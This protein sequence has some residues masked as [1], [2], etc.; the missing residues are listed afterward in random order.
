MVSECF[1]LVYSEQGFTRLSCHLM[2]ALITFYDS[3][4]TLYGMEN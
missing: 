4:P 1:P 2:S 3:A